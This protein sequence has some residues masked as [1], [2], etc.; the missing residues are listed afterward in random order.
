MVIQAKTCSRC[1]V[2]KDITGFHKR[3]KSKDGYA[4]ACKQCIKS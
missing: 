3:A 2:E 1:I 4:T